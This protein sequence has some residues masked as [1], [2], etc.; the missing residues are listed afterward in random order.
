MKKFNSGIALLLLFLAGGA[1]A[2][3]VQLINCS[4]SQA[5]Y[6]LTTDKEKLQNSVLNINESKILTLQ[7]DYT[8]P[9][10]KTNQMLTVSYVDNHKSI[11][12]TIIPAFGKMCSH[13]HGVSKKC[14]AFDYAPYESEPLALHLCSRK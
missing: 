5:Q 7:V 4:E 13:L 14:Y 9:K 2:L 10:S 11:T 6:Q 3:T 12:S 1:N 8:H